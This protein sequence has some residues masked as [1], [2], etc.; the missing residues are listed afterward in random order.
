LSDD[1]G[2]ETCMKRFSEKPV[3]FSPKKTRQNKKLEKNC[4]SKISYLALASLGAGRGMD[5]PSREDPLE[6][7][8]AKA[9]PR[10]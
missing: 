1:E 5:M 9:V 2:D 7:A 8:F 6:P 3:D 4:A 10:F